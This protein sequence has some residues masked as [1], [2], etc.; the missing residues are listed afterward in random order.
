MKNCPN[1]G[2]VLQ[3]GH[4]ESSR[5]ADWMPDALEARRTGGFPLPG[6]GLWRGTNCPAGYCSACKL[7]LISMKE[8]ETP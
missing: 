3:A 8:E 1:C 4:I 5:G 2:A 6:S 7:I